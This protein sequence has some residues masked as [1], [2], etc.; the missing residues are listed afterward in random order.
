MKG[1]IEDKRGRA[2]KKSCW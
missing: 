2:F 1:A